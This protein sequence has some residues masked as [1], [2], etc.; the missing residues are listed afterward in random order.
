MRRENTSR[1]LRGHHCQCA[2]CGKYFN[3]GHAFDTHRVGLAGIDRRCLSEFEMRLA[4]M[5]TSATGWWISGA[6]PSLNRDSRSSDRTPR[7]AEPQAVGLGA[8]CASP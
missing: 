8:A 5:S 6:R 4:G 1:A 7:L 3:S 2:S